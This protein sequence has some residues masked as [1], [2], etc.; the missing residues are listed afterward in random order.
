MPTDCTKYVL[1]NIIGGPVN[2]DSL[3]VRFTDTL[4]IHE[5]AADF[6]VYTGSDPTPATPPACSTQ[7]P[8]YGSV[9]IVGNNPPYQTYLANTPLP[10]V[11][12][13]HPIYRGVYCDAV[14][15]APISASEPR[16][17]RFTISWSGPRLTSNN[18]VACQAYFDSYQTQ[19]VSNYDAYGNPTNVVYIPGVYGAGVAG[20]INIPSIPVPGTPFST[21][22]FSFAS[23][24]AD[25]RIPLI[26][27]GMRIVCYEDMTGRTAEA[28]ST[29]TFT[30]QVGDTPVTGLSFPYQVFYNTGPIWGYGP[31]SLL[32]VGLRS[33]N[34]TAT[35]IYRREYNFLYNEQGW[36]NFSAVYTDA[37][38]LT[39]AD[40]PK[41]DRNNPP[42]PRTPNGNGNRQVLNGV[43]VFDMLQHQDFG[44][45][46]SNL[47]VPGA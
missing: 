22:G 47:S 32:F 5:C 45:L 8:D 39:P 30:A 6:G 27:R 7:A 14:I 1:G 37:R 13:K 38:G 10:Q 17:M 41:I 42:R 24:I 29:G 28:I 33:E 34:T 19:V 4:D 20:L 31:H 2:I 40:L 9:P 15:G 11:G 3:M 43:G 26:Q 16:G 35:P 36:D 44:Q 23:R 18:K 12:T 25:I 46:F 21:Q